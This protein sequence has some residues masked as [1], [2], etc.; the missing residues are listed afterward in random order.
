MV[1]AGNGINHAELARPNTGRSPSGPTIL[2]SILSYV[3]HMPL[4]ALIVGLLS[5]PSIA[6]GLSAPGL[7]SEGGGIS[8]SSVAAAAA[9]S[10]QAALG[11]LAKQ[12]AEGARKRTSGECKLGRVTFAMYIP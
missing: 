3:R 10:Q 7:A 2:R 11:T 1:V 5:G 12:L 9:L 4:V 6:L 8:T